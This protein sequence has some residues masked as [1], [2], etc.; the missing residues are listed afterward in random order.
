MV[1]VGCCWTGETMAGPAAGAESATCAV[2]A[3]LAATAAVVLAGA[4]ADGSAVVDPVADAG[5]ESVLICAGGAAAATV[6]GALAAIAAAAIASGAVALPE[7]GGAAG[8]LAGAFATE[9]ATA[10]G[11]G[12]ITGV[13]ACGA[14]AGSVAALAWEAGLAVVFESSPFRPLDLVLAFWLASLL[15]L[16]LALRSDA[17]PAS[18]WSFEAFWASWP[19]GAASRGREL[20]ALAAEWSLRRC[21]GNG[22]S[23]AEPAR[24]LAL[25]A[26]ALLS[27]RAPKPS[28]PCVWSA[29][30]SFGARL[31]KDGPAG[32]SEVTLYTGAAFHDGYGP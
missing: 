2:A 11:V 21:G 28:V 29:R 19:A 17:C 24:S 4:N 25:L 26:E 7:E 20:S 14:A 32:T 6:A 10:T 22:C 15:A 3:A 23:A 30:A 12:I 31:C 9:I 27:T 5:A 1:G 18:G 16:G 8:A 13:P